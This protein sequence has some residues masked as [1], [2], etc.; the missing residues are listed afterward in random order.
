MCIALGQTLF[1]V[2]TYVMMEVT[3]APGAE[4]HQVKPS[5]LLGRY[6]SVK[7]IYVEVQT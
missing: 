6:K 7:G 1:F 5:F 2:E 4:V 3:R